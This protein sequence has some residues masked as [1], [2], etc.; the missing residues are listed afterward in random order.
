MG[1]TIVTRELA[2]QAIVSTR[3]RRPKD[4]IPAFL[5]A[6]IGELFGRLG[7]L[8][9]EPAGPPFVLYHEFGPDEI[10]AEAC[11]PVMQI[12]ADSGTVQARVLP[13]VTVASTLHVGRYEDLGAAYAA[14]TDWIASHGFDIAGAVQERY[15]NGPGDQL[16]PEDYRTEVEIPVTPKAAAVPV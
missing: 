7:L 12:D 5:G 8:G 10:D 9:V 13:A 11:V 15:L 4:D 1:Y 3:D 2:P 16:R 14:L 6:S